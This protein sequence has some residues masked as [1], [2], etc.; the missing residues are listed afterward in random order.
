MSSGFMAIGYGRRSEVGSPF[1]TGSITGLIRVPMLLT[2]VA[3]MCITSWTFTP[4]LWAAGT[5]SCYY[6]I[7]MKRRSMSL[8]CNKQTG[9]PINIVMQP[10]GKI[11]NLNSQFTE[12]MACCTEMAYN[13]PAINKSITEIITCANFYPCCTGFLWYI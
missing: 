4:Q 8:G 6:C 10:H 11:E 7:P 9:L 2:M 13:P 5:S 1:C 12:K 3:E